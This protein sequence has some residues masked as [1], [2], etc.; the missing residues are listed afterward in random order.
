MALR[1]R[2][3]ASGARLGSLLGV[4]FDA[5]ILFD[6]RVSGIACTQGVRDC[7]KGT[8]FFESRN[9]SCFPSC[10]VYLMYQ[11]QNLVVFCQGQRCERYA[12]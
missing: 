2:S 10:R 8:R 5:M 12:S 4:F 1:S 7:I 6:P 11:R 3:A 9:A